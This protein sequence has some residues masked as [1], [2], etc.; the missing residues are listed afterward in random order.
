MREGVKLLDINMPFLSGWDL[1]DELDS[2]I[3]KRAKETIIC[4]LSSSFHSDDFDHFDN[5]SAA[6]F[7]LNKPLK[8]VHFEKLVE[9]HRHHT[10]SRFNHHWSGQVMTA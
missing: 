4:M 5:Q 1:L 8:P 7:F 2:E 3:K 10:H 9:S 6:A